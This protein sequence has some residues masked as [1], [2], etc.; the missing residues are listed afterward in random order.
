ML[1]EVITG[2]P[3][4]MVAKRGLGSGMLQEP[5]RIAEV[6][7]QVVQNT[8]L[9]VSVKMRLGYEHPDEIL[10]ILPLLSNLPLKYITI[11]P[12]I[13]KQLYK[14]EVNLDAFAACLEL[15]PHPIVYNGDIHT[16]GQFQE[17]SDRFPSVSRWMLGRGLLF[18]P[19]LPEMIRQKQAGLPPDWLCTFTTFHNQLLENYTQTLSGDS[20]LIQRMQ[21]FWDYFSALFPHN[22]KELKRIIK[23]RNRAE[24]HAGLALLFKAQ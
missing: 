9:K 1:Y 23:A 20:H 2:C 22:K 4:P 24:Y 21:S 11:H 19:F 5:Q 18:N 10:S 14:G 16:Y 8:P 6:L 7:R 3:Y 13:G 17:L 12:R 15:C